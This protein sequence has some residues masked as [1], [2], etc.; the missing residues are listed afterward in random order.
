MTT[1]LDIEDYSCRLYIQ[2]DKP[3]YA[4]RNRVAELMKADIQRFSIESDLISMDYEFSD[5]ACFDKVT[6]PDG[7]LY[8]NHTAY[9]EPS[10]QLVA[11]PDLEQLQKNT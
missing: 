9:I 4:M 5:V 10:E 2:S 11:K 1:D 7:F 3:L 8:Y 6:D